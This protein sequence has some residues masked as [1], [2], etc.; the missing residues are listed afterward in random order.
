[1]NGDAGFRPAARVSHRGIREV[2]E[3]RSSTMLA[4]D[5]THFDK[6]EAERPDTLE[7]PV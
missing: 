3:H 1:M 2:E 5:P 4:A 7:E 6:V